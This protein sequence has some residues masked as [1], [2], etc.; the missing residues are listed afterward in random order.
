MRKT[1]A[2]ASAPEAQRKAAIDTLV[3]SKDPEAL[4]LLQSMLKDA[5]LRDAAIR[6]LAAF[7]DAKTPSLI[8]D[9]YGSLDTN[10][11]RDA[12]NTLASRPAYA[13]ALLDAVDAKKL[14]AT[15]VTADVVRQL[16][17][18]GDKAIDARLDKSFATSRQTPAEKL[19][20]IEAAK[21]MLTSG[22]AGD[23]SRGRAVFIRT[24]AQCHTLFDAGA[25]IGPNITGANRADLNYL[26]LNII[27]PNAVIPAEY[28]TTIVRT[29]DGRVLTG[30]MKKQDEQTI[31]LQAAN[32]VVTLP[33]KQIDRM[34]DQEIS[35][36]PEG[37]F[38]G[39]KDEEKRDLIAYLQSPRQV[40]PPPGTPAA[41]AASAGANAR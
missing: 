22:P 35:M 37:L 7:E 21:A 25:A 15:D 32:E 19:K 20:G 26:L 10:A 36:M 31:T 17:N 34:K 9:A 39:L 24:C 3:A 27:D 5:T 38:D 11:K 18:L 16:R 14:L 23:P 2:D 30:I 29:K 13:T 28:R 4:P 40:A 12:I 1:L 41:P 33:R 6:G 8:L